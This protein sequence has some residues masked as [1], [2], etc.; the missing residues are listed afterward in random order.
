MLKWPELPWP[1][2]AEDDSS[3]VIREQLWRLEEIHEIARAQL[4]EGHHLL[5]ITQD[6]I[7]DLQKLCFDA[8][9]VARLIGQLQQRDYDKSLWCL[10]PPNAGVVITR[11][12]LWYPC[13][14]Y[15]TSRTE[16]LQSGWEGTVDYYLKL[17][18]HPSRSLI[19]LLSA[20][21]QS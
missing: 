21:L 9:D 17:C 8:N 5:P 11:E 19:L 13:D 2:N 20:H 7:K 14:A 10:A 3:R 18:L 12:K 15:T 4:R 16:R 6:C 1:P